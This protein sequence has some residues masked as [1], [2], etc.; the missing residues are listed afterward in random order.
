MNYDGY[1]SNT[2]VAL[3]MGCFKDA[4]AR[5]VSKIGCARAITYSNEKGIA[6][7]T[8]S[9]R[10]PLYSTKS[11][12]HK[13]TGVSKNNVWLEIHEQF[14]GDYN[15][16]FLDGCWYVDKIS[17]GIRYIEKK[18]YRLGEAIQ[19][20]YISYNTEAYSAIR[21]DNLLP[22]M[23]LMDEPILDGFVECFSKHYS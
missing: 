21:L 5:E 10:E 14:S 1:V 7:E 23:H 11:E 22:L 6:L 8:F 9:S 2:G 12:Q 17:A 13:V 15:Y 19:K 16:L 4:D 3:Y 20:E 18:F